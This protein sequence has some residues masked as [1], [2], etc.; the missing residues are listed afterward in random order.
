[1]VRDGRWKPFVIR[2]TGGLEVDLAVVNRPGFSDSIP[3]RFCPGYTAM[4]G[5]S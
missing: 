1:M 5:E 2:R 4:A 3:V